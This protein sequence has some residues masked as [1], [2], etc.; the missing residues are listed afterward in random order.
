MDAL[1]LQ[2][3]ADFG[4]ITRRLT[5]CHTS[6]PEIGLVTS[7]GRRDCAS[8][9]KGHFA[10]TLSA[11]SR[12]GNTLSAIMRHAWDSASI[13]V[14][15]K[16]S[17][18]RATGT[19]ISLIVHVTR[20]ELVRQLQTTE[21]ASGFA[22]RFLW[23]AVTRSKLL[24]D[25]GKLSDLDLEPLVDDVIRKV[26]FARAIHCIERDAEASEVWRGVYPQLS[27][28]KLGLLGAATS[29]AEAH[30]MRFAC[31][32]ALL[33][34]AREIQ[35]EHLMAALALWEYSEASARFIFG[36]ALGDPLAD[37][38]L[39]SLRAARKGLTRTQINDM[40]SRNVSA[41]EITRALAQLAESGLAAMK[42]EETGGRPAERW[43]AI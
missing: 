27:E 11:L 43:R 42:P 30:V 23:I 1:E 41:R 36:D 21:K 4:A 34:E 37:D 25:G 40:L 15:T 32:Y 7:R 6:T 3:A 22:N 16:K 38:L 8:L 19:H 17:P 12:H 39:R 9:P 35:K 33:D 28:G 31:I 13:Q 2:G 10:S 26:E 24:P 18:I 14:L 20:E 29:R 5:A